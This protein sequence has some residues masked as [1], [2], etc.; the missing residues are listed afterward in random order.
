MENDSRLDG[1]AL[2]RLQGSLPRLARRV[3]DVQPDVM[4]QVVGEEGFEGVAGHVESQSSQAVSQ[5]L[6]GD[7]VDLI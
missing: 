1:N 6:L 5:R 7:L 2:P 3:V 4:A